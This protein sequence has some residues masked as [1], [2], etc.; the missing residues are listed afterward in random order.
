MNAPTTTARR[1]LAAL[2]LAGVLALTGCGA[3]ADGGS[4]QSSAD[5]KAAAAPEKAAP[6]D[7][8]AQAPS[9]ATGSSGAKGTRTPVLD[10]SLI[11][12][13][14]TLTVEAKDVPDAL[15][16]SRTLVEAAGGYIGDES[17]SL[18]DEGREHSR[19]TLRVPPADYERVLGDLAGLGK[20]LQRKVTAEDV[21]SQVVDVESRIKSQRASVTRVRELMDR[22]TRLSDVVTLEGELSTRQADLEALEAQQASLKERTGMATVTL[23]LTEPEKAAVPEK[24]DGFWASVGD[25]LGAGWHAFY[26]TLRALLIA[27]AAVLPFAVL[28]LLGVFA[29]RMLR[30]RRG[31]PVAPAPVTA[32]VAAPVEPRP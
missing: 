5:D 10:R 11:V 15:A 8:M 21:T 24:A 30:R 4:L 7:G 16:E 12:R 2:A 19:V 3:S 6:A 9:G 27:L 13:T 20:L 29:V 14:A 28:A 22:A 26:V 23:V 25:A 31:G 18:D 1:A 32:P 17:T